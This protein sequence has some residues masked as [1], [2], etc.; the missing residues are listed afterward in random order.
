MG[1]NPD[2]CGRGMDGSVPFIQGNAT[3]IHPEHTAVRA[4]DDPPDSVQPRA[5]PAQRG[6]L[7]DTQTA[8][9]CRTGRGLLSGAEPPTQAQNPTPSEKDWPWLASLSRLALGQGTPLP[10]GVRSSPSLQPS[11]SCTP[12]TEQ[13]SQVLHLLSAFVPQ[14]TRTL[15]WMSSNFRPDLV[16]EKF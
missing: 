13:T 6:T 9:S 15:G 16:F 10:R 14:I 8:P 2:T 11:A 12:N 3:R 1:G 4:V 7:T 5:G